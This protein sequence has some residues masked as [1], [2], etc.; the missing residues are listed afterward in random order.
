M[1]ET[2][3][4]LRKDG[5]MSK[6]QKGVDFE[7]VFYCVLVVF[8]SLFIVRNYT[9]EP[10]TG[11]HMLYVLGFGILFA[12]KFLRREELSILFAKVHLAFLG[13][14]VASMLSLI[15]VWKDNPQYFQYSADVAIYTV[16]L[17]FSAFFIT[18]EFSTRLKIEVALSAFVVAATL[19]SVNGMFNF[20]AGYDLIIG[21]IGRSL[22]SGAIRST[23]GNPNFVSDF[24]AMAI[25]IAVYFVLSPS[26]FT[27][28]SKARFVS[29]FIAKMFFLLTLI[30]LIAIVYL[31]QTR[32][33]FTGALIGNMMFALAAVVLYKRM[34]R[35]EIEE[36]LRKANR[37]LLVLLMVVIVIVSLLYTTPTRFTAEGKVN[38]I[39]KMESL[40]QTGSAWRTR[41]YAWMNSVEQIFEPENR[42]RV[43]F[44][45]GIGTFQLYHLLYTP[46]VLFEHP[47]YMADWSNFKRTHNDYLQA[48]SETGVLGFAAILALIILLVW[49]Y[50]SGLMR[51]RDLHKL[52]LLG[53]LGA[54]IFTVA[55]HSLFEFPLHMQPNLMTAVFIVSVA[56]GPYFHDRCI[57]ITL[58]K[59][60]WVVPLFA[61]I[62]LSGYL[63]VSAFLGEGAFQQGQISMQHYN[64]YYRQLSDNPRESLLERLSHLNNL[65]GEF[66][67]LSSVQSYF[68]VKHKELRRLH[69]QAGELELIS[70]SSRERTAEIERLRSQLEQSIERIDEI[71]RQMYEH[72]YDA[73]GSYHRSFD[74]YPVFGKPL[75]YLGSLGTRPTRMG[76]AHQMPPQTQLSILLG[77]DIFASRVVNQFAGNTNV[78]PLPDRQIRLTPFRDFV[79]TNYD[80][81]I[82]DSAARSLI[83]LPFVVQVQML[84]DAAN[85][86][87]SSV[88]TFSERQTPRILGRIY[89]T[90]YSETLTYRNIIN[91]RLNEIEAV[92][93]DSS[94][95]LHSLDE[96]AKLGRER[97]LYWYDLGITWLP[98]TWNRYS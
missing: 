39:G 78:I 88:I 74:I 41:L 29:Q 53:A 64:A 56:M 65:E 14:S 63:K 66:A 67:Y 25:P 75:W 7:V 40:V 90:I 89:R 61:L 23:I 8:V 98:A 22:S 97:S 19:V 27:S 77:N 30:P 82:E 86:Y 94:S 50:F 84:I 96:L 13:F 87:E 4:L 37:L 11:K 55:F 17:V 43:L 47:T 59:K 52:L 24:A 46:N 35:T 83:V 31:C 91:Q 18:T 44:G 33:V 76:E 57:K 73:V 2:G 93:I 21:S 49:R 71:E 9:H 20:Y 80:I 3:L 62:G 48:L 10:S 81:L 69:P 5:F 15:S 70:I 79:E 60:I 38:I 92:L 34:K 51:I 54:S 6:Y 32:T 16:V 72:F 26:V 45:T 28:P 85:Y 12:A 95:F 36:K 42:A 1:T 68:E 58:N